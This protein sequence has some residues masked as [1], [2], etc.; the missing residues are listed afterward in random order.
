[1]IYG[2]FL[3]RSPARFSLEKDLCELASPERDVYISPSVAQASELPDRYW[4]VFRPLYRATAR[5]AKLVD[6]WDL[7]SPARK[8]VPVRFRLRAP[9][10]IKGLRAKAN[11]NPCLFLV[12]YCGVGPQLTWLAKLFCPCG[13]VCTALSLQR[14]PWPYQTSCTTW[15]PLFAGRLNR[16]SPF[17]SRRPA[18][19][20][21]DCC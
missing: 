4:S 20:S 6:A 19:A 5:M 3:F 21:D 14:S 17:S 15:P 12:R 11:A 1:M 2:A 8:G 9:S 7:K 13:C 16:S 18:S 10:K